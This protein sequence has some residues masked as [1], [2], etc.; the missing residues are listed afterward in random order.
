MCYI[1]SNKLNKNITTDCA[2]NKF[3]DTCDGKKI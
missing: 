2:R 1:S 3:C